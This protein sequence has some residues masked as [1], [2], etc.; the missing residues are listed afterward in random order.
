MGDKTTFGSLMAINIL[1]AVL[2]VFGNA[3]FIYKN[4]W[5]AAWEGR[6]EK[7]VGVCV[8]VTVA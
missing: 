4:I 2:L 7:R 1:V 5:C 8:C 3:S 6:G